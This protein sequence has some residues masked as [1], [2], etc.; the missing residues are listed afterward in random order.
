MKVRPMPTLNDTVM[1]IEL[2]LISVVE[3]F[4]LQFLAAGAYLVFQDPSQWEYM[5]YIF[6]GLLF[7]FVFWAQAIEHLLSFIRWPI[8]LPHTLFYF[9]A[10]FIQVLAFSSLTNP[11]LWFFWS[12]VFSV[13]IAALYILDLKLLR[14]AK[15]EL[16]ALP[17]GETLFLAAERRHLYEMRFLVPS[18]IAFNAGCGLLVLLMPSVFIDDGYH[19]ILGTLQALLSGWAL[20]DALRHFQERGTLISRSRE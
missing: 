18:V 8:S 10:G 1:E 12:T 9:A 14:Q 4:A 20:L 5:P 11:L 7:L 15:E 6:G 19:I 2:V 17:E 13:M 3:G 16:L